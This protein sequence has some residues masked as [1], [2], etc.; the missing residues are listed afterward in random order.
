MTLERVDQSDIIPRIGFGTRVHKSPFFNATRRYGCKAY[1]IYN[2][3]FMPLYYAD[4]IT[5]FWS[6]VNDVT[7]WDVSCERQVEVTGP[8]AFRFVQMLT[9]RNLTEMKVGQ[10]KY[11]LITVE[12]GGIINDP[13]LLR[14]AENHFWISLADADILLWAKGLAVNTGLDVTIEEPDV[15]PIQIQGPKSAMLMKDLFGDWIMDLRYYWFKETELNGIP[16]LVSRTG[17]SSEIGYE[18][19]LRDGSRGDELWETIMKAGKKYNIAPG[20]PSTIRRIEGGMMSYGTDMTIKNN[21]FELGMDRL[22]DLEQETE[23]IGKAALKK[24]KAEGVKQK[25]VGV[26]IQAD[27][28]SDNDAHWPVLVD[29]EEVGYITSAVY[30]PRLQKNIGFAMVPIAYTDFGTQLTVEATFGTAQ[31]V[32]VPTPFYDPKKKI[33]T[34]MFQLENINK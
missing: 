19:F 26:E 6:L 29:G 4:P 30:S 16:M 23:F 28:F 33:T 17:W 10:C 32:V 7:L 15:S 31:A 2:H 18:I 22:I 5:D 8:D 25:L 21:P 3:M 13:I 14:L 34:G 12:D 20:A 1:S 24:I 9:P 11:I 27:P